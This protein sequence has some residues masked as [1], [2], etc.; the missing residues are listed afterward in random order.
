[1]RQKNRNHYQRRQKCERSASRSIA[2]AA[3]PMKTR[4]GKRVAAVSL[5]SADKI[6]LLPPAAAKGNSARAAAHRLN[7]RR[8]SDRITALEKAKNLV[9]YVV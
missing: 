3:N 6:C 5:Y 1:M 8:I 7:S 9:P 2:F 4:G